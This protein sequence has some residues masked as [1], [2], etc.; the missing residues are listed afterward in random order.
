MSAAEHPY[1]QLERLKAWKVLDKA[2][3][4]LAANGDVEELTARR[5]IVGYLLQKLDEAQALAP[6]V[7]TANGVDYRRVSNG[8]GKAHLTAK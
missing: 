7:I 5:Y 6:E 2:I 4:D 1:K 8:A 3:K